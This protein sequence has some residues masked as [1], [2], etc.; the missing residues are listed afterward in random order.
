[1]AY[2]YFLGSGEGIKLFMISMLQVYWSSKFSLLSLISSFVTSF[3][4]ASISFGPEQAKKK[5]G[6]TKQF[7]HDFTFTDISIS[8][9]AT[10]S[11][12]VF[13]ASTFI[14]LFMRSLV[15][16]ASSKTFFTF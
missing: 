11:P 2:I 15:D 5:I 8:K 16:I 7:F 12:A 4:A 13:L 6:S 9:I 3:F 10:I 14:H 1:M